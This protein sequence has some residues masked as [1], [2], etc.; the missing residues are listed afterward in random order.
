M[1]DQNPLQQ[2]QGTY[3]LIEGRLKSSVPVPEINSIFGNFLKLTFLRAGSNP[4]GVGTIQKDCISARVTIENEQYRD[5]GEYFGSRTPHGGFKTPAGY[6]YS[7]DPEFYL[8]D[9][10]F[11]E[12]T[13]VPN[14]FARI[15][16]RDPSIELR[17]KEVPVDTSVAS[18]RL[19]SVRHVELKHIW[20]ARSNV[21]DRDVVVTRDFIEYQP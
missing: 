3:K 7:D 6:W 14:T 13:G 17:F 2:I 20:P 1:T 10:H 5:V 8:G 4:L 18:L 11:L 16:D 19:P 15:L 9:T 12:P 21:W